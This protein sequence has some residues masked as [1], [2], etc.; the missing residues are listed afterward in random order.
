MILAKKFCFCISLQMGCILIA[1]AGIFL[2][3]M[4]ID[5]MLLCLNRTYFREMQHKFPE[6]ALYTVIQMSPDLLTI[7]ASFMLI[8]AVLSQY[9]WLFWTTLFFQAFQAVFFLIFSLASALMGSNLII[10]ESTWHNL[11]YW[12]YVLLWLTMTAYFMY[13]IYSY[14]RQLKPRETENME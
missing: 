2:A 10:N 13:I 1:L 6:Q 9:G 11:T 3:G 12:I 7:L 4:N 14:Y 5:Y 8:F